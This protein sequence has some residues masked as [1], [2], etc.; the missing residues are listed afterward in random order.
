MPVEFH[1]SD[2]EN[3]K[4]TLAY[5]IVYRQETAPAEVR[6]RAQPLLAY[7]GPTIEPRYR[8]PDPPRYHVIT[9]SYTAGLR[10]ADG[11]LVHLADDAGRV[12]HEGKPLFLLSE[13]EGDEH[14]EML[15][16]ESQ[17][18]GVWPGHRPANLVAEAYGRTGTRSQ[19]CR[20]QAVFNVRSIMFRMDPDWSRFERARFTIPGDW[21]TSGGKPRWVQV[22]AVDESGKEKAAQPGTDLPVAAALL[23]FP[24]GQYDLAFQFQPPQRVSFNGAGLRFSLRVVERDNWQMGFCKPEDFDAW[25]GK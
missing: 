2:P 11:A 21:V 9:S 16:P 12:R 4:L 22:V 14:V 13:G 20:W 6:T 5:R 18:L 3:G 17:E 15:G 8:F 1:I 25:R 19:R 7:V 23:D 24:D 10:M